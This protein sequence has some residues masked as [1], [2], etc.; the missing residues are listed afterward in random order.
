MRRS[1]F[2][3]YVRPL[4]AGFVGMGFLLGVTTAASATSP[5]SLV[6][7]SKADTNAV[8]PASGKCLDTQGHCTLRAATEVANAQAA[9][10][11]VNIT[12]PAGTFRLTLGALN[13][14]HSAVTVS[15]AGA[16]KTVVTAHGASRVLT[17]AAT[18]K[19]TLGHLELIGGAA[20]SATSNSQSGGNG[21]G[22]MN[23]GSLT[24]TSSTI[25]GNTAGA[26][27]FGGTDPGGHG[28]NGGGIANSGTV[29]ITSSTISGNSA[30]TG[31]IGLEDSESS[32]PGGNGGGIYSSGG[33][34]TISGSVVS[35]NAAGYAGTLGEVPFPSAGNGGGIWNSA[36]LHVTA[37]RFASNVGEPGA[38]GDGDGGAIFNSGTATIGTSTFAGND[39]G[40]VGSVG[41]GG[42]GGNGGAIASTGKLTLTDS[43]VSGNTA[44]TGGGSSDGGAGGGL[45]APSGSVTLTGDTLSSNASGSGGNAIPVD[46]GCSAP[47]VGGDGGAVYSGATLAVSNTTIA[48]NSTGQGGYLFNPCAGQAPGGV[49]GGLAVAGGSLS[50]S[51]STVVDNSDGIT[52]LGGAVTLQGTILAD[53]TAGAN[54]TGVI[55]EGSGYN[56][57][58]GTTCGFSD[59]NDITGTEP[60]LAALGNNG[61][62]T[63]TQALQAGSPAIDHGGTA[64]DGCPAVD[65]RGKPRPDEAGDVG[66]CDIGAYESQG[67]A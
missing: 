62:P 20:P 24:L 63:Q 11:V 30:G 47:G 12:V 59:P 23:A 27:G 22:I 25:S 34:V 41:N 45:Y 13:L 9:G 5:L 64:V 3:R 6:V 53:S 50:V 37:T 60:G 31:G 40:T 54:C 26:G 1:A 46:P 51:Y 10:K 17:L 42:V 58:S 48:D 43:T 4:L 67:V 28:G 33:S 14:K 19:A 16:A 15:G 29:T 66:A 56:L 61:G 44:G 65:Q 39:A 49:G 55:G 8:N 7:N 35:G 52:N 18:A 21:G 36:V 32:G 2:V 57:D 38:G